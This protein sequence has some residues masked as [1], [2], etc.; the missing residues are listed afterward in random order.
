MFTPNYHGV[1]LINRHSLI[2]QQQRHSVR[3]SASRSYHERRV[4]HGWDA[5]GYI[6]L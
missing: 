3:M 5:L 2:R 4:W 1:W 6:L